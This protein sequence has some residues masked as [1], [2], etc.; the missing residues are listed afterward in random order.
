[1][2]KYTGVNGEEVLMKTYTGENKDLFKNVY[3]EISGN[4]K[5][6][7]ALDAMMKDS[8]TRNQMVGTKALNTVTRNFDRDC[9][10]A[11]VKNI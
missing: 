7:D 3:N 4:E 2:T 1:M 9:Q 10:I 5:A 11:K 6:Y 8:N